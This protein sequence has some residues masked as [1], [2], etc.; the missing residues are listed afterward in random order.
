V[1]AS[2]ISAI[3]FP[4][5]SKVSGGNDGAL[6]KDGKYLLVVSGS[7]VKAFAVNGGHGGAHRRG[8][9][10]GGEHRAVGRGGDVLRALLSEQDADLGHGRGSFG[11]R[12]GS[13][14][15]LSSQARFA[16]ASTGTNRSPERLNVE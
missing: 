3:G 2:S 14:G 12:R 6:T 10:D 8:Q 7:T 5:A 4:S 1:R 15:G 11:Q 9:R 13:K 16:R